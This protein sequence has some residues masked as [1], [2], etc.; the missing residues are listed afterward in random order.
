MIGHGLTI[1]VKN[2]KVVEEYT[3]IAEANSTTLASADEAVVRVLY[4]ADNY[5][6]STA[7]VRSLAQDLKNALENLKALCARLIRQ[8]TVRSKVLHRDKPEIY[9]LANF[10]LVSVQNLRSIS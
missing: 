1:V 5:V 7:S 3:S 10:R 6:Y 8:R 4:A 9:Q 2:V